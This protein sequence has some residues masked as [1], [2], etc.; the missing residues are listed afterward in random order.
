MLRRDWGPTGGR[1]WGGN[2]PVCTVF[3]VLVFLSII[4]TWV[5]TRPEE[6]PYRS[7]AY[8]PVHKRD[9]SSTP[10]PLHIYYRL[11][12]GLQRDM[13]GR[14][15]SKTKPAYFNKQLC[16]AQ[17]L[18]AFK[19]VPITVIA[20]RVSN[21]TLS[22]VHAMA[23]SAEVLLTDIGNGGNVFLYAVRLA[24][25]RAKHPRDRLY[26]V[27]DDYFHTTGAMAIAEGLAFGDYASG[28]DHPDK[29]LAWDR[30]G[31]NPFILSDGEDTVLFVSKL[32]HWKLT[33]STTMTFMTTAMVAK[34][35]YEVYEKY[36]SNGYPYDFRMFTDLFN[37]GR[38]VVSSVP[39]MAAHV[40]ELPPLI[41]WAK[42][43]ADTRLRMDAQV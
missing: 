8:M 41:D 31:Q 39:A 35:D 25:E 36:C 7:N 18:Q 43:A 21:A 17:L 19:G 12:D 24:V 2:V 32:S 28:H 5:F 23:P 20:D 33:G 14:A 30:G 15:N 9:H 6:P 37:L 34:R 16:L 11:S 42:V 10:S 13:Y 4:A 38:R 27:E 22:W 40:V 1:Q 29:Y 26:F 3:F